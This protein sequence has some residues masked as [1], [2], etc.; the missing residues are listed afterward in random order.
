MATGT[1]VTAINCMDG[2]TQDPVAAWFKG[3]FQV[4]FV[5]AITE[6]G[7][8]KLLS[9]QQPQACESIKRRVMI[10]VNAHHSR[11]VAIVSHDDC[12]GNPVSKEEHLRQLAQCMDVVAGWGLK[13]VQILGLWV[14]QDWQVELIHERQT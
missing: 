12:A 5:D 7:P 11:V 2:R 6:S 13:G 9:E 10:S 14:N 3:R 4:D 8:D 1:F